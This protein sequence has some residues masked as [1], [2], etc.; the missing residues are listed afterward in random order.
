M[1]NASSQLRFV[2]ARTGL[3][4]REVARRAGT[5]SATLSRYEFGALGIWTTAN[6]GARGH[7]RRPGLYGQQQR[8]THPR[9]P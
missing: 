8:T 7:S 3:S 9:R 6:G 4:Q 2:R 1:M 5:S